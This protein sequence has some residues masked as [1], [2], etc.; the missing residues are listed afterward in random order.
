MSTEDLVRYLEHTAQCL[1]TIVQESDPD[2]RREKFM[3]MVQPVFYWLGDH[4]S[5]LKQVM[6]RIGRTFVEV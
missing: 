4:E 2:V 1:E 3:G 6:D 5:A